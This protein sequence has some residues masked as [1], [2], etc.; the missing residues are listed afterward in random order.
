MEARLGYLLKHARS[1]L[2]TISEPALAVI[3]LDGRQFAVLSVIGEQGPMAQQRVSETLR[4]DRTTIV[5]L[6]DEL[7]RKG[8]VERKRD[9]GDRR[10]Y[11]V[12]ITPKGARTLQ[13]A[14]TVVDAAEV[15]FTAALSAAE[16]RQL[17]ELL[18]KLM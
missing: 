18:A 7:E 8:F 5:A 2:Q 17:R 16:R 12:E 9:P 13:R 11:A 4:V 15:E 10:A 3:D 1:G 14:R 6:V